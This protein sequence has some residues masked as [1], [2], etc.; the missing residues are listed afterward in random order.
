LCR[1][2]AIDLSGR[3]KHGA[4]LD[5]E[6]LAAVYLELIGGRQPGLDLAGA[7]AAGGLRETL[8]R[9]ARPARPHAPSAAEEAAHAAFLQKLK[10]PLWLE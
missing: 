2:F 5:G 4:R 9:P 6:L 3:E 1:R 8:A 10:K 7:V